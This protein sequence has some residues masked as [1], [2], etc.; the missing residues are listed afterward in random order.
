MRDIQGRYGSKV[1]VRF[2]QPSCVFLLESRSPDLTVAELMREFD[3]I[4]R[5]DYIARNEPTLPQ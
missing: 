5:R 2:D 3:L 4:S 1:R